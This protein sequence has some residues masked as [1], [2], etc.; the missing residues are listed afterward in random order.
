MP[1]DEDSTKFTSFVTPQGQ[2]EYLKLPFGFCNSPS[3]FARFITELFKELIEQ[4][5]ILIYLDDIM[6]ATN[7]FEENIQILKE[8]FQI[9]VDNL[10]DLKLE[11]CSFLQSELSYLGYVI[12]EIGIKPSP[13]NIAAVTQ[14]PVPQNV[15]HVQSFIG[16]ASY[17]RRF[18]KDFA[19]TAKPL[20]DLLRKN[21]KFEFGETQLRA[22]E[23]L[24]EQLV[25]SPVLAIYSPTADTELHCDASNH[26][27]GA[28][29]L[30]RQA[31]GH[32]H[33]VSYFS[34]RTT[35]SESKYHSYELE[36][37]ISILE[38]LNLK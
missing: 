32:L 1:L 5:K 21:A 27:Y 20:Y 7:T 24:K 36:C 30:Q 14:F 22:M 26:G 33:P 38:A 9:L 3:I 12:N 8:V 11:K 16:L 19:N 6:I 37:L 23:A 18:V 29:L 4:G 28:S 10:V 13:V 34:K 35:D 25:S 17:F 2:F 31:D 15:K